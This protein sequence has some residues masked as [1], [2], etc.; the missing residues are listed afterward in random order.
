[1]DTH[2][3]LVCSFLVVGLSGF[4]IRVLLGCNPTS[5]S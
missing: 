5:L 2:A 4:G 1:M 3:V